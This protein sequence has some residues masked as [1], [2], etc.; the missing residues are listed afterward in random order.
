MSTD[1]YSDFEWPDELEPDRLSESFAK[2]P[3]ST[4]YEWELAITDLV[5]SNDTVEDVCKEI[6]ESQQPDDVRFAALFAICTEHRRKDN[7]TNARNL[8]SDHRE[9]KNKPMY[10]HLQSLLTSDQHDAIRKSKKA[11]EDAKPH[12]GASHNLAGNIIEALEDG[13]EV[14]VENPREVA[15]DHLDIALTHADYP[16][17][18]ATRGLL[19]A[20][21]NR[22]D[23]AEAEIQ[24][25]R[26]RESEKDMKN[27]A[28]RLGEY[29]EY[30]FRV[31]MQEYEADLKENLN[32]K[33]GDL[34]ESISTM[35]ERAEELEEY[36]ESLRTQT[37]QFLGFFATL[38]AVI[39]TTAQFA[40]QVEPTAAAPL[41]LVM[42]GGLLTALGGFNLTLPKPPTGSD[43]PTETDDQTSSDDRTQTDNRLYRLLIPLLLGI[44]LLVFGLALIYFA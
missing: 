32:S 24:K 36:F 5:E 34:K 12:P 42:I 37:L 29:Q 44:V 33:Y 28:I 20:L 9:F 27:Y 14:P 10:L 7:Y 23:K 13:I 26:D 17:H 38:L 22:F 18:R 8:L 41:I 6:L 3:E 2:L 39:I 19:L 21:E 40:T 1:Q 43:N 4:E 35:E 11:A 25:A 16:K 30:L 31:R 15:E